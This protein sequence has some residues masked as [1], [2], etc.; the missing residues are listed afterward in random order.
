MGGWVGG[1]LTELGALFV[2]NY[3]CCRH[4]ETGNL[5]K[6]ENREKKWIETNRQMASLWTAGVYCDPSNIVSEAFLCVLCYLLY[7]L[8]AYNL[9]KK[10]IR[11]VKLISI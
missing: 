2:D 4:S 5:H 8:S 9:L 11:L 7:I 10:F 3:A 1:S 6:M